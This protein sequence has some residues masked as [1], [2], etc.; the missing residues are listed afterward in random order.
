MKVVFE[1]L[2]H[3]DSSSCEGVSP[4]WGGFTPSVC[5]WELLVCLP[6]QLNPAKMKS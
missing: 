3:A 5:C 4:G 2:Q 1:A 6:E